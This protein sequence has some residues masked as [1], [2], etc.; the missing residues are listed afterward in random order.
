MSAKNIT[1]VLKHLSGD[2]VKNLSEKP[3]RLKGDIKIYGGVVREYKGW[4]EIFLK[5]P[6]Q[7]EVME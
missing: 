6:E 1:N 7:L 3:V 2:P 5:E 4:A